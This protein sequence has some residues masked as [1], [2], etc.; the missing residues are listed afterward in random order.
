MQSPP[1]INTRPSFNKV[2]VCCD[3]AMVMVPVAVQGFSSCASAARRVA[4]TRSVERHDRNRVE[5]K[6]FISEHFEPELS[7]RSMRNI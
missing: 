4:S 6:Y 2:A 1:A 3:R 5:R 7:R